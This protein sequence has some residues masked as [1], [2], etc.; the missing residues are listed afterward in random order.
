VPQHIKG[1]A[2]EG[3]TGRWD[4]SDTD[5]IAERIEAEVEARAPGF[6]ALIRGRHVFTPPTME[7]TNANLVRGAINGGTSQLHQQFIFRPTLGMAGP[8]TPVRRLFLASASAHPGGGVHGTCGANA[9]RA[10]L[11][12]R[13]G[14]VK[15][16][17]V[18][19]LARALQRR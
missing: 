14:Q 13:H 4:Q 19:P 3:I 5:R 2:A 10:A 17:A 12:I 6:R 7:A 8:H 9:A 1:D 16:T 18:G 15:L 11:G